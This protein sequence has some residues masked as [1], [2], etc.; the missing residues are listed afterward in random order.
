MHIV[1]ETPRFIIR[2]FDPDDEKIYLSLF[3]NKEVTLHLPKRTKQENRQLFRESLKEY[4]AGKAIGRWGIFNKPGDQFI[5][6]CLLR[7]YDNDKFKIELGYVLAQNFWGLG[8]AGEM[9]LL[10][11]DYT[12]KHTNAREIVAV[13]TLENIASQK[14][15][16]NAGL[17]RRDNLLRDGE[18][19]AFFSLE[20]VL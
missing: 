2:N 19:L 15:L 3:E 1:A 8:I 9:A 20:R 6:I 13:T 4:E 18:E 10:M 16:Q 12:F 14:V 11:V 5:G 7:E 17:K